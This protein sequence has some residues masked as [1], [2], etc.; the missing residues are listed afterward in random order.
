M[1]NTFL[2]V[3]LTY[4]KCFNTISA[5]EMDTTDF[6]VGGQA[7]NQPVHTHARASTW[8]A[9]QLIGQNTPTDMSKQSDIGPIRELNKL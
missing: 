4:I 2:W 1:S 6:D 8:K 7:P 9:R 5:H 3:K